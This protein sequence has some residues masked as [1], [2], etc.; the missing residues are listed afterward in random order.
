MD[1]RR[2]SPPTP[3]LNHLPVLHRSQ[4]LRRRGRMGSG[5]HG[6]N[7]MKPSRLSGVA[8][9]TGNPI[10]TA[11]PNPTDRI[12]AA[13]LRRTPSNRKLGRSRS[14]YDLT[15]ELT[16]GCI[17]NSWAEVEPYRV[18]RLEPLLTGAA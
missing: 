16:P 3:F 8:D 17:V 6:K 10:C 15:L 7:L 12:R 1:G 5:L 4:Y 11:R 13:L 18:C 9:S 2:S 14:I